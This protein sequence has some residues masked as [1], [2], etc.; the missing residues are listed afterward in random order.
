MSEVIGMRM[1][2]NETTDFFRSYVIPYQ[3]LSEPGSMFSQ[4]RPH[5]LPPPYFDRSVNQLTSTKGRGADYAH[6]IT[7]CPPVSD[8]PTALYV[9]NS[10]SIIIKK[11]FFLV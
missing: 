8:L 5:G 10:G 7:T 11:H 4:P 6:H 3:G 2:F 1:E 9:T